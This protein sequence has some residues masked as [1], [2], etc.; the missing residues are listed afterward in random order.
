MTTESGSATPNQAESDG[1]RNTEIVYVSWGGT[2]RA[3]TLRQAMER[4]HDNDLSLVYLAILDD[5]TFGDIDRVMLDLVKDELSWLLDAQIEL[6]KR[7]SGIED[8]PIRVLVQAGDVA[9][10]IIEAASAVGRAEVLIGAP[11]PERGGDA[12][13]ELVGLVARRTGAP[14]TVIEP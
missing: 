13:A 6:S 5:S 2:G 14:V 11:I 12:I 7:Q 3:A 1:S 9:E 10:E 8:V 4:A